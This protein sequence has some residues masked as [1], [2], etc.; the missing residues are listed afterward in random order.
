[1]VKKMVVEY[2]L[3]G[4]E[5]S[6]TVA[7]NQTLRLAPAGKGGRLVIRRA[8]Y[9]DIPDGGYEPPKSTQTVD[10]TDAL[11][12][13]IRQGRLVAL[14]S[15][16]LAGDP[17]FK[18]RKQLRLDYTVNGVLHSAVFVENAMIDLPAGLPP[19]RTPADVDI[20]DGAIRLTA[21][22]PGDVEVA[23]SDGGK[24]GFTFSAPPPPVSLAG[25][26]QVAFPPDRGAP[27]KISLAKLVSW[28]D[29]QDEGVRHF[30]G[31]AS[32]E[33][34][35]EIPRDLLRPDLRAMLDLGDVQVIAEPTLNGTALGTLWKPPFRV[36]VSKALKPGRN[37]LQVNVTNLWVNRLIGDEAKPDYR[38]WA[39]A[40]LKSWPKDALDGTRPP[41]TGRTT[42]TTWKHYKVGDPLL[43]SGLIGPVR[44]RFGRV[45]AL[46]Q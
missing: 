34:A 42:W 9:G 39:G 27:A 31:T 22:E 18:V 14:A 36:D 30:S 26:W 40:R 41:N 2:E 33:I 38:D 23:F 35:F 29:H 1:V 44:I 37:V 7:E 6:A 11:R 28:P 45:A 19:A 5:R 24:R 43:P 10:V 15:N 25:P 20:V 13:K 17:A 8:V 4:E 32:Y 12:A 16:D 46:P 3:D 21:W